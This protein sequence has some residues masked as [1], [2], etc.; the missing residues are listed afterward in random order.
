[1]PETAGLH[2]LLVADDAAREPLLRQMVL[3]VAPSARVSVVPVGSP[4]LPMLDDVSHIVVDVTARDPRASVEAI[5]AVRE[6]AF[7]GPVV[8][9]CAEHTPVALNEQ[10]AAL[11]GGACITSDAVAADPLVLA[12]ALF[13]NGTADAPGMLALARTRRSLAAGQRVLAL[14]HAINNPLAGLLAESQLLQL[15]PLPPE[16]A[17]AV[18]RIVVLCRRVIAL[19]RQ[20][21]G[22]E[23]SGIEGGRSGGAAV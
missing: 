13:A 1:M 5:R 23:P 14:Q 21:D 16:Q 18:E 12:D 6:H 22:T 8:V 4:A 11:T 2:V 17:E 3:A 20:L 7:A 19:V 15:E 9:V 10:T